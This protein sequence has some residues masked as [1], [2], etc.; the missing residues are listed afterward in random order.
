MFAA[1]MLIRY[2][3]THDARSAAE[4]ASLCAALSTRGPSWTNVQMPSADLIAPLKD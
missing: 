4:F 3:K 2:A 1:A